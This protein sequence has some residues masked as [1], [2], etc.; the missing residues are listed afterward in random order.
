MEFPIGGQLGAELEIIVDLAI[1]RDGSRAGRHHRLLRR[2]TQIDDRQAT[3]GEP[4][5]SSR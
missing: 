3:V 1:I 5:R 4:D 2:I